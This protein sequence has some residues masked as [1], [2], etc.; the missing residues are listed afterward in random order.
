MLTSRY[1][2]RSV[3][4]SDFLLLMDVNEWINN[5]SAECVFPYLNICD[6]FTRSHPSEGENRTRNR[7]EVA[8]VNWPLCCSTRLTRML[9]VNHFVSRGGV[10]RQLF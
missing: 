8:R 1:V 9:T 6:W 5:E 10:S 4:T 7:S 2:L 3:H